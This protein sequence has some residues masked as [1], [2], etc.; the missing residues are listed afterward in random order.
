MYKVVNAS[1][2]IDRNNGS[3]TLQIFKF[4]DSYM[5]TITLFD[6]TFAPFIS[7]QELAIAIEKMGRQINEDYKGESVL[8]VGVL[9]GAFRFVAELMN[10]IDLECE[11][12]FIKMASYH[13]TESSGD[14]TQLIGFNEP[15]EGRHVIVLEDI[16]D[17]GNT[18]V[19]IFSEME[20]FNPKSVKLATLLFKPKAYKKYFPIDYVGIEIPNDFIV[21]YGLDYDGLGRNINGIYKIV[22]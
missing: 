9:N 10:T 20:Q 18:L 19:K 17:T 8:F 1:L 15:M 3:H 16:V 4:A 5:A 6:K 21:G 22:E 14:V 11:V 13:K 7:T 12:S 2:Y